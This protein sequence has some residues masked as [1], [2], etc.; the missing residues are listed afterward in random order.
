MEYDELQKRI[1]TA[2]GRR[3]ADLLITNGIIA[4]VY[5][6]LFTEGELAVS[7][8][9]IA[10]IGGKGTYR[11]LETVDAAGQYLLPGL[12]DSHIHIES[13]FLCPSELAR[14]LVPLGTS[15]IIADPHE[16]VNVAGLAGLD[17][18][19]KAS[20]DL[21]LDIK[22]MLP[23]CVPAASFENS[24]ASLGAGDMKVPLANSR[25]LGLGEMMN[26]PGV[27]N[28]EKDVLDKIF[29]ALQQEKLIDGHSPGLGGSGLAAYAAAMIHTDHECSG[30]EE[31][32][33]RIALGMYIL[34]RQGSACRDLRNLLPG[35]TA[36]N[37]RRCVLC[38]DDYQPRSILNEGHINNDIRICVE[39]G[40]D[41]MTALRMATLNAAEC[42]GLCDR[43][44]F[45]PG[46]RADIV[47]VNNLAEFK[48][49]KV[50][51]NGVLAAENGNYLPPVVHHDDTVLRNSIHVK[52]F[53]AKKLAMHIAS[54]TVYVIDIKP[55][56]V[57][58]GKGIAQIRKNDAGNFI[59]DPDA[60]IAK[61]AV[62]ERHKN[63][64]NVG[65]GFLRG[66][67]IKRG[68]IAV[69]VA[70]DSHNI[71]VVGCSDNEMA[72]AVQRIIRLTGGAALVLDDAVIDEMPLPLGGIMSDR[73]GEWVD[74]K[75]KSLGAAAVNILGVRADIEPL[76]TLCFMALPVIPE[77]KITDRGLF[78]VA[79]FDFIPLELNG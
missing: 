35:V 10:A 2:S 33:R 70:H 19:L 30:A 11:G 49:G 17:Y 39:F 36:A 54:D 12:I 26:Y 8:G 59:F 38:S 51:I 64:G 14:L 52:D 27:I 43:G 3:P 47:L 22:F 78:D 53:S 45:S 23:S 34:L 21:A 37:S 16:I 9:K 1:D 41:P 65:L 74:E 75:L 68:A 69:S 15:T 66:Y 72:L 7:D 28:G 40:L 50:F 32:N 56:G 67:G 57:L 44:G 63:T 20:E 71:I 4:D 76:M 13:S 58:T 18:M 24:G 61:I 62:I 6:G 73:P 5:S 55:D 77:L 25:I 29:L 46:K 48:P 60:D 42:Y 79:S 31:M